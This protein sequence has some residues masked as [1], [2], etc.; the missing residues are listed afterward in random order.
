[1]KCESASDNLHVGYEIE[2]VNAV[3]E[4]NRCTIQDKHRDA[5]CIIFGCLSLLLHKVA[6][7]NL[8]VNHCRQIAGNLPEML[9]GSVEGNIVSV[10]LLKH[11]VPN[12]IME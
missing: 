10:F 12:L 8:S 9:S 1:M 3:Q 7:E 11:I 4:N 2:E 5:V 6:D